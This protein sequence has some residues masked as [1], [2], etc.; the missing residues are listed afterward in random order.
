M[1]ILTPRTC[2]YHNTF[3]I[4]Q[5]GYLLLGPGRANL[6]KWCS[7]HVR[8]MTSDT[9]TQTKTTKNVLVPCT[10]K[11]V[12][13]VWTGSFQEHHFWHSEKLRILC[14]CQQETRRE[15][16][17]WMW[18]SVDYKETQH[19]ALNDCG[20]TETTDWQSASSSKN[21]TNVK[22]SNIYVTQT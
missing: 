14:D 4:S 1:V 9:E 20:N 2:H 17:S 3:V 12:D 19:R 13:N 15:V 22:Y 10:C 7:L 6:Q 8:S 18:W 5:L 11:R 16:P 21:P